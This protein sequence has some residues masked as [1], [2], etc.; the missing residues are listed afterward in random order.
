MQRGVLIAMGLAVAIVLALLLRGLSRSTPAPIATTRSPV[1]P[2]PA[3]PTAAASPVRRPAAPAPAVPVQ[4][5]VV[6]PVE[7]VPEGFGPGSPYWQLNE[8]VWDSTVPDD[9]ERIERIA[10]EECY[11]GEPGRHERLELRYTVRVR[12]GIAEIEDLRVVSS[13]FSQ[14]LEQCI[15]NEVRDLRWREGTMDRDEQSQAEISILDLQ[16]RSRGDDDDE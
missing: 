8:K 6:P 9:V 4:A 14:Q 11:R 7:G 13:Q 5:A 1:P 3:R 16:K 12:S 10:A 15:V 2:G